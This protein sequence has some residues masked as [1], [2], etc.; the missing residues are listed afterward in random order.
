MQ[1]ATLRNKQG[2]WC[3]LQEQTISTLE[4][5][6]TAFEKQVGQAMPGGK[7]Q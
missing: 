7:G 2:S 6:K 4:K 5:A 1:M 3:K